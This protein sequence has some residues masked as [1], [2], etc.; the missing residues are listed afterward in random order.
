MIQFSFQPLISYIIVTAITVV[1][2][3][4]A[5]R[6][7]IKRETL[8]GMEIPCI[9]I[10]K[11]CIDY[12]NDIYRYDIE[13]THNGQVFNKTMLSPKIKTTNIKVN[14]MS[15]YPQN[16]TNI[17][18][19]F[20]IRGKPQRSSEYH[21]RQI[22]TV[23]G[24]ILKEELETKEKI[25]KTADV[26]FQ[27]TIDGVSKE[28]TIRTIKPYE[29]NEEYDLWITRNN[30]NR[31]YEAE[32][33][34]PKPS[35][36]ATGLLFT[37]GSLF[38]IGMIAYIAFLPYISEEVNGVWESPNKT[39]SL[40]L[41]ALTFIVLALLLYVGISFDKKYKNTENRAYKRLSTVSIVF[42][43]ILLLINII[44]TVYLIRQN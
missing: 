5:G 16:V 42:A 11:N 20:T 22:I 38:G 26:T 14:I 18:E 40:S 9:A 23:N 31:L 4:F 36:V 28:Y 2:L 24:R 7:E 30:I 27:Y 6:Y 41:N 32:Y 8:K 39:S 13:Y 21:K 17:Y 37:G 19:G 33:Q 12:H 35:E 34:V 1:F 3:V 10:A 43:S 15:G 44:G 25:C 29:I